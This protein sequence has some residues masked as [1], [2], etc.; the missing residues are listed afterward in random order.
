MGPYTALYTIGPYFGSYFPLVGCLFSGMGPILRCG[1]SRTADG[2]QARQSYEAYA[3]KA[4][5]RSPTILVPKIYRKSSNK[6]K[7]YTISHDQ[8]YTRYYKKNIRKIKRA[9]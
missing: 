4:T 2:L 8:M 3:N 6:Y 1:L 7:T 5:L 9:L